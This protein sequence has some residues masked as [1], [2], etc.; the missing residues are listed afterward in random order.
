MSPS[1]PKFPIG[2]RPQVTLVLAMSADGKI[3]DTQHTAARFPSMVDKHHLEQRITTADAT[4]FGAGTL[5]A[6]GTTALIK[7]PTLVEHRRQQQQPPQPIQIV[8]SRSGKLD[9]EA[10][11]FSQPVPRWLLTTATGAKIWRDKKAFE[12]IWVAPTKGQC[13]HWPK[14][15]SELKLLNINHLLVMGG[16]E[17]V[18]ALM[19]ADLIDQLWL[20]V[21]PLVIGGEQAPTPCDGAGFSLAN[22]PKFTLLSSTTVGDE[23]FLHYRRQRAENSAL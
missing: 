11:F 15:L 13:F 6:Y 12:R 20:T 5:R 14:I 2:Q 16:G 8:C 19:A 1:I 10:S 23:V 18:A 17:L 7:D 4:L 22:A 21:C 3:S 9:A